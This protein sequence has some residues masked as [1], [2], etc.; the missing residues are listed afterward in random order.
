MQKSV[1][2]QRMA[3]KRI[4]A[5]PVALGGSQNP[6]FRKINWRGMAI[7]LAFPAVVVLSSF[8]CLFAFTFDVYT[9]KS[10][11]FKVFQQNGY[12]WMAT[13]G[14]AIRWDMAANRATEYTTAQGL[15]DNYLTQAIADDAGN[16]WFSSRMGLDRFDGQIWHTYNNVPKSPTDV[17]VL[18]SK[19]AGK[20]LYTCFNYDSTIFACFNGANQLACNAI[21]GAFVWTDSKKRRWEWLRETAAQPFRAIPFIKVVSATDTFSD[22]LST[23]YFYKSGNSFVDLNGRLWV[24]F[25][26]RMSA[27]KEPFGYSMFD[28][29]AWHHIQ[30]TSLSMMPFVIDLNTPAAPIDTGAGRFK[31]RFLRIDGKINTVDCSKWDEFSR[32]KDSLCIPPSM[33]MDTAG[34]LWIGTESGLLCCDKRGATE[35]CFQTG[36]LGM[37]V[38]SQAEDNKGNIWV[39]GYGLSIFNGV[40]WTYPHKT[41]SSIAS[42]N[43]AKIVP[44]SSDSGGVWLKSGTYYDEN[45]KLVGSGIAYYNGRSWNE[46]KY[47]TKRNGLA[48]DVVLDMA[49]DNVNTLWCVCGEDSAHLSMFKNNTWTTIAVPGG[50]KG[51]V[52]QL[53]IDRKGGIWLIANN[54]ARFDGAHWQ[55]FTMTLYEGRAGC[56]D[57]FEDSKGTMWFATYSQGLYR[58]DGTNWSTIKI[59][60]ASHPA[61]VNSIGEDLTDALWVG[62]GCDWTGGGYADC[63]GLWRQNGPGWKKFSSIDGL[64]SDLVTTMS[65]DKSG[66]M[67]FACSP[68]VQIGETS[69]SRFDG[70]QWKTFTM[71]DGFS[72]TRVSSIFTAKNGDIWFAT[73]TGITRLKSGGLAAHFIP[74]SKM[75][76]S[77]RALISKILVTSA[78][79]HGKM[80]FATLYDIQGRRVS[81]CPLGQDQ[82]RIPIV[83]GVYIAVG[84]IGLKNSGP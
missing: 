58:Y 69:V 15:S 62:L 81:L 45:A 22:T 76:H 26:S 5:I 29:F 75:T 51:Q 19:D 66:A 74:L 49:I 13:N 68:G 12:I 47:Y 9:D 50:L 4:V 43:V 20:I 23:D 11:K 24:P 14:G 70:A 41:N 79:R 56:N 73:Y 42:F 30:N 34:R 63:K 21:N 57:V 7:L 71:K 8:T 44:S 55:V 35:F 53:H 77:D 52:R 31:Y 27:S 10:M 17:R 32:V 3:H 84:P 61:S 67:W 38:Y 2:Q 46:I 78:L 40:S 64:G 16:V 37:T 59:D 25:T 1:K 28:G 72:D 6:L 54:P 18:L 80:A 60:G 39:N 65:C 82:S 33:T 48:S 36:P 83:N